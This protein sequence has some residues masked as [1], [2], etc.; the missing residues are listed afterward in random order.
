MIHFLQSQGF[1]LQKYLVHLWLESS[2][3]PPFVGLKA[4]VVDL[5]FPSWHIPSALMAT[6]RW[7]WQ[8][9]GL[10]S[11]SNPVLNLQAACFS[12]FSKPSWN[13]ITYTSLGPPFPFIYAIWAQR[14]SPTL[15]MI[16][17]CGH[18]L[19]VCFDTYVTYAYVCPFYP[20]IRIHLGR[21]VNSNHGTT[22]QALV[23][24][25]AT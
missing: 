11:Q 21:L 2:L 4:F 12:C 13:G 17:F 19:H 25:Y 8:K 20:C 7:N 14:A 15:C 3:A 10:L 18:F 23:L 5:S 9:R 24:D 6:G 16:S 22:L 1:L